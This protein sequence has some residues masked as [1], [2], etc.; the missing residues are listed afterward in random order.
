MFVTHKALLNAGATISATELICFAHFAWSGFVTLG[1]ITTITTVHTSIAPTGYWK[2]CRIH[3]AEN[4][5]KWRQT[6][7]GIYLSLQTFSESISSHFHEVYV[8]HKIFILQNHVHTAFLTVFFKQQMMTWVT[9]TSYQYRKFK[10]KEPAVLRSGT[11][12]ADTKDHV[13]ICLT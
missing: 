11:V 10:V 9:T 7:G 8:I 6:H 13:Y 3:C 12:N 1:F 4:L 5:Y 2:A